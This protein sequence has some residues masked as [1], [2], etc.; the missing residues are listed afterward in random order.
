MNKTIRSLNGLAGQYKTPIVSL[1]STTLASRICA[2]FD[3]LLASHTQGK[4]GKD[5]LRGMLEG[6]TM[7][8]V[9][10]ALEIAN[11]AQRKQILIA[12]D[13]AWTEFYDKRHLDRLM[14]ANAG[15]NPYADLIAA[16]GETSTVGER[17]SNLIVGAQVI[18]KQHGFGTLART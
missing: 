12:A 14:H 17:T 11:P 8:A 3:Q 2:G 1:A 13:K 5:R 15:P 4:L 10:S 18:D 6:K 16:F 7:S 9:D